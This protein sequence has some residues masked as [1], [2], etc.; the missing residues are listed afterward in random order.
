MLNESSCSPQ[1]ATHS[2]TVEHTNAQA[3]HGPMKPLSLLAGFCGRLHLTRAS[4]S[5]RLHDRVL[6]LV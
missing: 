2:A 5:P 3:I 6:Y 4:R 1:P